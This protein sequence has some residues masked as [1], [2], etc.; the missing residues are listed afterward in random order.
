M[1]VL[2][3]LTAYAD[4]P[5]R[6]KLFISLCGWDHITASI[7]Q[8]LEAGV[9]LCLGKKCKSHFMLQ[10][11]HILGGQPGEPTL[12]EV[13][14]V[15]SSMLKYNVNVAVSFSMNDYLNAT[16]IFTCFLCPSLSHFSWAICIRTVLKVAGCLKKVC[17]LVHRAS[18]QW[19]D[20]CQQMSIRWVS[21]SFESTY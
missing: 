14:K 8:T 19:T 18:Q 5:H 3:C 12:P 21:R 16:I 10:A 9:L 1:V 15:C 6:T 20:K 11:V 7:T 4:P 17:G 2:C 13:R